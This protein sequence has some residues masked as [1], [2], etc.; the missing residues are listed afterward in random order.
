M[1]ILYV[2]FAILGLA[3]LTALL[4]WL[5]VTTEGVYLGRRVVIWLYDLYARRYDG[6]KNYQS[7]YEH[8]L[9]AQP[10][11]DEVA[12]H[13]SPLILDVATGTGR[14]P[15]AMLKHKHFQGHII[16]VDLSRKMLSHAA[17]KL[18]GC[19]G[20]TTLIWGPAEQLPFADDTFDVVTCLEALEFM[21][22]PAAVLREIT[23]VLRPGGVLLI[24]N[25][26][27]TQMMPGKTWTDDEILD[28]LGECGMGEAKIEAW[29]EDYNKV[30]GFKA[31]KALPTGTRPLGEVLHCPHCAETLLIPIENGWECPNCK[32][33]VPVEA[34]GVLALFPLL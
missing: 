11:M 28:L 1:I 14:L 6:I 2:F 12:P 22:N 30:W 10:I 20:F 19:E 27:G 31:G 23:R 3:G 18:Q 16:G 15:V 29:Q 4:W 5:L 13:K 7:I 26:I 8:A 25:R 21:S 17:E 9:I 34:D 32:Q 33:V 24:T